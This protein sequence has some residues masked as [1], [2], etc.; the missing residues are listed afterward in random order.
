M[1]CYTVFHDEKPQAVYLVSRGQPP[2]QPPS[3]DS[4]VRMVDSLIALLNRK[5]DGSPGSKTLWIGL[6]R[7]LDYFLLALDAK[8]SVGQP[9]AQEMAISK[10]LFGDNFDMVRRLAC[11]KTRSWRK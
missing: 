8:R 3:P 1:P 6:Q 2:Q 4:I 10:S 11:K 9:F 7:V 5:P